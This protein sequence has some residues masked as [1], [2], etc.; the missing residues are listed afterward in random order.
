MRSNTP[1]SV[2]NVVATWMGSCARGKYLMDVATANAGKMNFVGVEIRKAVLEDAKEEATRRVIPNLA[3]VHANM[4][5]QQK[6]LLP[7]FPAPV[8]SVSIFHPD[9]WMKKRHLKRRLVND[10][11]VTELAELLADGT[12]IYVQ[13]DVLELYE[14]I[15]E[16]FELSRLYETGELPP[17]PLGVPT[18]RETFVAQQG[19]NIY[20]VQFT[21]RKPRKSH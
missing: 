11:F 7:S 3:L 18:D 9:P 17:S 19:G 16:V 6:L 4:N 20:R 2:H 15:V 1:L 14:Y 8:R 21:V 5:F 13:T 12:P 10:Q